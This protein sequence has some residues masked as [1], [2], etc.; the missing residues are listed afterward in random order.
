M[1]LRSSPF[2]KP[3]K[4]LRPESTVCILHDSCSL[5][6]YWKS[7]IDDSL[8]SEDCCFT[9]N[10]P[11][12]MKGWHQK[13]LSKWLYFHLCLNK[14]PFISQTWTEV[15]AYSLDHWSITLDK[16]FLYVA[17]VNK[18]LHCEVVVA[19]PYKAVYLESD[20]CS[21]S[22][23]EGHQE[24][25]WGPGACCLTQRSTHAESTSTALHRHKTQDR[26]LNFEF[27]V[28]VIHVKQTN[29]IYGQCEANSHLAAYILKEMVLYSTKSG[30]SIMETT[31]GDV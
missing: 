20:L 14:V 16:I 30:Y 29:T 21:S 7:R 18:H 27:M 1:P 25:H 26:T 15:A 4:R 17:L 28:P 6:W 3:T 12:C 10:F 5:S 31:F 19:S 22:V 8:S 23:S 13:Y 11:S 24:H 2:G 9:V